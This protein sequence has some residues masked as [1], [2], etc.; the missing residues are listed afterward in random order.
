MAGRQLGTFLLLGLGVGLG[1]AAVDAMLGGRRVVVKD[2][3]PSQLPSS[4]P[5]S[6]PSSSSPSFSSAGSPY[7]VPSSSTGSDC[8]TA[9]AALSDCESRHG[10]GSERCRFFRVKAEQCRSQ[11][12]VLF[13]QHDGDGSRNGAEVREEGRT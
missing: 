2:S 7:S 3:Y 5:T 11:Q 12:A 8:S 13:A 10:Y 9:L 4:S 6:S 1:F